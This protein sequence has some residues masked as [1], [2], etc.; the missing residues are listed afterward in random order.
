MTPEQETDLIRQRSQERME[1]LCAYL[2][3]SGRKSGRHWVA[4]SIDG[5]KGDSWNMNLHTGVFGD[6]AADP[7][8]RQGAI[9]LW[10]QARRV[11]FVTAKRELADWLGTPI[12]GP[13]LKQRGERLRRHA[14]AKSPPNQGRELKFPWDSYVANMTLERCEELHR[15]RGLSHE[16]VDRLVAAKRIGA[17]V[18][19]RSFAPVGGRELKPGGLSASG[20]VGWALPVVHEGKVVTAHCRITTPEGK[21]VWFYPRE[22]S[23]SRLGIGIQPLVHGNLVKAKTV[24]AFESPWDQMAVSDRFNLHRDHSVATVSTRGAAN[25]GLL[26]CVPE[27]PRIVLWPQSDEAG[28]KWLNDAQNALQ[29]HSVSVAWVPEGFKDVGEFIKTGAEPVELL[30]N[31]FKKETVPMTRCAF[32]VMEPQEFYRRHEERIQYARSLGMEYTL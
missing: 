8:M 3:P 13:E 10:M 31:A 11:N 5:G 19:P 28:Q 17:L 23:P 32:P 1:G 16:Y 7:K 22:Y 30:K 25:A 24:Y 4:G 15:W 29:G 9:D 6:F 12:Q 27:R 21:G 2:I 14:E 20:S 18:L 26:A